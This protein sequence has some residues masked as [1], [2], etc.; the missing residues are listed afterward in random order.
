[1]LVP[2]AVAYPEFVVV[3]KTS[4]PGAAKSIWLPE[5]DRMLS[6]SSVMETQ[7]GRAPTG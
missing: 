7:Y 4:N 1:M 3:E 6:A 2:V 5:L